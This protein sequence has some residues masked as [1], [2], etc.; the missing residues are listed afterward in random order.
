MSPSQSLKEAE[1]FKWLDKKSQPSIK[2]KLPIISK[3]KKTAQTAQT[4]EK[5][6]SVILPDFQININKDHILEP[7]ITKEENN[8]YLIRIPNKPSDIIFRVQVFA[9]QE[10]IPTISTFYRSPNNKD[11]HILEN[12][13]PIYDTSGKSNAKLLTKRYFNPIRLNGLK[14]SSLLSIYKSEHNNDTV[15]S[16]TQKV[17]LSDIS[18]KHS[19]TTPSFTEREFEKLPSTQSYTLLKPLKITHSTNVCGHVKY[20]TF[21]PQLSP[22]LPLKITI[23]SQQCIPLS[24]KQISRRNLKN[25]KSPVSSPIFQGSNPDPS[26]TSTA[27]HNPVPVSNPPQ[28]SFNPQQ[29]LQNWITLQSVLSQFQQNQNHPAL[30]STQEPNT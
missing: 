27:T 29:F 14:S 6:F 1:V 10:Q 24:G 19:L 3:H 17:F 4:A 7:S 5:S 16:E 28:F 21:K 2:Q 11:N 23:P 15:Y 25:Y 13:Y 8:F 18:E 20:D 26:L 22:K 12:Q 9:E 30:E